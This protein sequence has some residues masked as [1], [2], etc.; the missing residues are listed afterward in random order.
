MLTLKFS[1]CTRIRSFERIWFEY[2]IR[3]S[4]GPEI[5]IKISSVMPFTFNTVDLCVLI[6]NGRPWTRA[7]E[8]CYALE[9]NKETANIVKNHCSKEKYT[10]KY[11]MSSVP[12]AVRPIN[13]QKDSQKYGIYI[14]EEEMYELVFS[15]QQPKAKDFRRHCC[16]VIFPQI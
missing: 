2:H 3:T 15:S 11:Q 16:N 6:I 5:I 1:R 12:A 4:L 10:Q 7:R 8:V 9:Y 13:W 14:N